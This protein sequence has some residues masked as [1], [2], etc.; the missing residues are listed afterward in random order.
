MARRITHRELL[1][2]IDK[3]HPAI[4]KAFA[5]A[6]T[7]VRSQ[8]QVTRIAELIAAGRLDMVADELGLDSPRFSDLTEEIRKV[9]AAGGKEGV[10]E[11][12][13]MPSQRGPRGAI[14]LPGSKIQ[15]SFDLR[16]QRAET[17]LR[18]QSSRMVTELVA[19]QRNAIRIAVSEGTLLG[20][21]PRQTALDI[22]GRI[23]PN[24]RR[25]G[26][27]VGLTSQQTQFVANA[28]SQLLSGNAADMRDYLGRA[29]RDKRFD[30]IV[31]K[32]IKEGKAVAGA[33]VDRIMGRYSD[34]LLQLRGENIARTE[35]LAAFNEAR[36][37]AFR[38]AVDTGLV[39]PHNVR[40]T[41]SATMDGR[42]RDSHADLNGVE[43][44][45]DEAFDSPTG[46]RMMHPGDTSLGAGAEDVI[47]CRCMPEYRIDM[48]AETMR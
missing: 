48:I 27:I 44:G 23:G 38:Q 19:D 18:N 12:A 15:I 45:L 10:M 7:N 14:R 1:Q 28:R 9:Y 34:R 29:R 8:A 37:E 21:G 24:G 2:K 47:N 40:K 39:K 30:S 32:A 31:N 43:V 33:D 13:G 20:N 41:W 22:V 6:F 35:A 16:N 36:E 5:D 25:S 26:G 17:W 46:A 11:L 42:T 3:L 4:A